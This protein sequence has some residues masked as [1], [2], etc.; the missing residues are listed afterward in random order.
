[1]S[2]INNVNGNDYAVNSLYSASSDTAVQAVNALEAS[3]NAENV[4]NG[5]VKSAITAIQTEVDNGTISADLAA[6]ADTLLEQAMVTDG[7]KGKAISMAEDLQDQL[8][9]IIQTSSQSTTSTTTTEAVVPED[10]VSISDEAASAADAASTAAQAASDAASAAAQAA[11]DNKVS[12]FDT[13]AS[14]MAAPTAPTAP[15]APTAPDAANNTT[16]AYQN[17]SEDAIEAVDDLEAG[18]NADHVSNKQV[19]NAIKALQSE[20]DDGGVGADLA[21]RAITLLEQATVTDGVSGK[22]VSKAENLIKD[23]DQVI[24]S[25]KIEEYESLAN[26]LGNSGVDAETINNIL[27]ITNSTLEQAQADF[28]DGKINAEEL[29]AALHTALDE[30]IGSINS[31]IQDAEDAVIAQEN[32]ETETVPPGLAKKEELPPGLAKKEELPPGLAMKEE[33]PPGLAKKEELPPGLAMKEELPPGLAKK[34]ELPPGLEEKE[35]LPPGL[36][37]K[38]TNTIKLLN[39]IEEIVNTLYKSEAVEGEEKETDPTKLAEELKQKVSDM[40]EADFNKF[41]DKLRGLRINNSSINQLFGIEEK[42]GLNEIIKD[43]GNINHIGD[44]GDGSGNFSATRFMDTLSSNI[45]DA[46]ET[47]KEVKETVE[48]EE[49]KEANEA[50]QANAEARFSALA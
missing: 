1:M 37:K 36:A 18:L 46:L 38:L 24:L 28:N 40:E 39:T 12:I 50:K 25:S 32:A 34:E 26:N 8:S 35:E 45:N 17:S 41:S 47:Y 10:T 15:V 49:A 21:A 29:S 2:Y 6:S 20:A 13:A 7:V 5:S 33:L 31:A 44:N 22:A 27:A 3:L 42:S 30:G 11:S 48:D 4:S 16:A 9:Q 14:D 43:I 19:T 23:L